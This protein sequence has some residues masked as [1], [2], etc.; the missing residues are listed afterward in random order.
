MNK[1]LLARAIFAIFTGCIVI[2][3]GVGLVMVAAEVGWLSI[4]GFAAVCFAVTWAGLVITD[5]K[6]ER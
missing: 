3:L 1:L 2:T 4:A 5:Q 6:P